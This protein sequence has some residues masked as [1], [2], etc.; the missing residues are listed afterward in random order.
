M[1]LSDWRFVLAG[2]ADQ[3]ADLA[4]EFAGILERS[5]QRG[6][7][8]RRLRTAGIERQIAQVHRRN[9]D[10][11]RL[12]EE[13]QFELERIPSLQPETPEAPPS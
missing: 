8:A 4:D 7:A 13:G 3:I 12:A 11:M 1:R 6:D 5:A 10:K 2:L 9:A